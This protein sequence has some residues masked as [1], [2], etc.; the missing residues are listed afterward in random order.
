[1]QRNPDLADRGLA[2][3]GIVFRRA[4][5]IFA[6]GALFAGLPLMHG[7]RE[8]PCAMIESGDEVALHPAE[9]RIDVFRQP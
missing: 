5:P 9:G 3:L 1:M 8:D 4:S 2:P 7:L 6:Q